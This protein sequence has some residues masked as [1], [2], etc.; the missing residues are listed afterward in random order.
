MCDIIQAIPVQPEGITLSHIIYPVE[1]T[2]QCHTTKGASFVIP[3]NGG[4]HYIDVIGL[5]FDASIILVLFIFAIIARQF[6]KKRLAKT[7]KTI[8]ISYSLIL[9][10]IFVLAS[11]YWT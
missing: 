8:A 2:G 3:I 11:L 4:S 7:L 9:V 1:Y 5:S 6:D 10:S